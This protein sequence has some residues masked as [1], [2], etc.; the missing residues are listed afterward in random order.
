M[1]RALERLIRGEG[2]YD[3]E[4][5]IKRVNDGEVRFI[6]SRAELVRAEDGTPAKVAGAIQD[7]SEQRRSEHAILAAEKRFRNLLETIQLV[8]I[9]LD[10]N[11]DVSFCNDYFLNLTGWSRDEVLNRSWFDLFI[12]QEVRKRGTVALSNHHGGGGP[13]LTPRKSHPYPRRGIEADR[14]G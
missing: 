14:L 8:A 11:G 1:D 5:Q 6:H 10:P 2:E 7:V 4:F 13:R 3:E 12:P 9:I